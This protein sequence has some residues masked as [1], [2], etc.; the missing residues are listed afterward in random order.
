MQEKPTVM[1]VLKC[2]TTEDAFKIIDSLWVKDLI[3]QD[4]YGATVLHYLCFGRDIEPFD[5]DIAQVIEKIVVKNPKILTLKYD[6]LRTPIEM[7]IREDDLRTVKILLP[8]YR[9]FKEEVVMHETEAVFW[10]MRKRKAKV[11]EVIVTE[12][13][14][15][16]F[17]AKHKFDKMF[18]WFLK[19]ELSFVRGLRVS[20]FNLYDPK[21]K[22][23]Q[24]LYLSL[25][26][27]GRRDVL[28]ALHNYLSYYDGHD[29]KNSSELEM[30]L[31]G[32]VRPDESKCLDLIS[33]GHYLY[34]FCKYEPHEYTFIV[35]NTFAH[36][37]FNMRA[38][39]KNGNNSLHLVVRYSDDDMLSIF[40]KLIGGDTELFKE[41][42]SPNLDGDN[43]AHLAL[44]FRDGKKLSILIKALGNNNQLLQAFFTP[45]KEGNTV[46]HQAAMSGNAA[47]V[48][49]LLEYKYIDVYAKNKEGKT[50][51]DLARRANPR[52]CTD[53]DLIIEKHIKAQ[54]NK[55]RLLAKID[56]VRRIYSFVWEVF[57]G[58][59]KAY[60][61]DM[62]VEVMYN[63][64][65]SSPQ[66]AQSK[67][68]HL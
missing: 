2:K 61:G 16:L 10:R 17:A 43:P 36:P 57:T 59:S 55:E 20:A 56:F 23:L 3:K 35:L 24:E 1:D 12:S 34:S 47:V 26:W 60:S 40:I 42:L 8:Y 44:W 63:P 49:M 18:L 11:K 25:L 41:L 45:D 14:P 48:K 46:L 13:H 54:E 27:L 5:F 65:R 67:D 31:R 58:A 28:K 53:V 7:A 4:R 22:D 30:A 51:L 37:N 19:N 29:G 33:K 62:D 50:A 6:G 64:R 15:L 68:R 38:R 52:I 66:R 39:D 21:P 9:K 32:K